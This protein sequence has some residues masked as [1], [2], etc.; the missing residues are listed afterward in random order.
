MSNFI[1]K[2]ADS[3]KFAFQGAATLFRETPN[4]W[5]HL[6][7]TVLAVKLGFLFRISTTEWLAV[8]IVIGLVLALEAINTAIENLADFACKKKVHPT[9]KKVKDLSAAGVL[10]ASISALVVGLI[11]FLPKIVAALI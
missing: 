3:F 4:A 2:R 8:T 1:K 11:I 7:L 10:F 5:I 6:I 9:I